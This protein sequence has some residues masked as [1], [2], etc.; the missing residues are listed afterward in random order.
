MCSS[1]LVRGGESIACPSED[2]WNAA[3]SWVLLVGER[4]ECRDWETGTLRW[5]SPV[6]ERPTWVGGQEDSIVLATN[7]RLAVLDSR[8]GVT[9]WSRD[10][11]SEQP[12][13]AIRRMKCEGA[14][15]LV[16]DSVRG[17]EAV[18]LRSGV[19]LW[20][21]SPAP[22]S[23]RE[24]GFESGDRGNRMPRMAP[25]WWGH[26]GVL[27]VQTVSPRRVV[28]LEVSDGFARES[29]LSKIGRAHV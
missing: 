12:A 7:A 21:F 13:G 17:V 15:L 1:D 2:S 19:V 14:M 9:R 26:E 4:L 29:A 22:D 20:R 11:R 25:F 6:A 10:T 16:L 8:T 24:G 3:N 18:D 5:T 23:G 28:F 27:G